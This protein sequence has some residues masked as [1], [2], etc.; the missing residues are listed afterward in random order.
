MAT[1]FLDTKTWDLALDVFGNIAVATEP[2]S[3]AQDAAS[4]CKTWL[5]EVYF[6]TTLGIP[7]Q[8]EILGKNPSVALLKAELESAAQAVP[9][10]KDGSAVCYLSQ[11]SDRRITGQIQ[12]TDEVTGQTS[13]VATFTVVNPQGVG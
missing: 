5:G 11:L 10:V 9:G 3:L 12:V 6:D 2:Y 13:P 7:Y 1:I 8:T 4:A